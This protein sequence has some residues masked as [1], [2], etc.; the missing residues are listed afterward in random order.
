MMFEDLL[1]EKQFVIDINDKRR[2]LNDFGKSELA[3]KLEEIE[4][5]KAKLRQISTLPQKGEKG[6]K[7]MLSSNEDHTE[8]GK[9]ADIIFKKVGVSRGTYERAKFVIQYGTE[10]QKS[11]LRQN[12]TTINKEYEKIRRDRRKQQ[13][14]S[15]FGINFNSNDNSNNTENYRLIN[16]DFMEKEKQIIDN[17]IDLIL[18]DPPYGN[19]AFYIYE[20]LAWLADRV[21]KPGGSLVFYVGHLMLERVIRV[22]GDNTD[23]LKYWW[24]FCV[25]HLGNHT[26]IHAR[27]IFAEWKPMLWYVKGA[28]P[29]ESVTSNTIGDFIEST[30][31]E[32]DKALHEWEQSTTD[33]EYIIKNLTLENLT[34]LD[35]MM[36]SGTTGVS[37][38][39][40]NRKFIGFEKDLETFEIA[41]ARLNI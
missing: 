24:I 2:Q 4:S 39:N 40:L 31:P 7:S 28:G 29:N 9:T 19:E 14:L 1:E 36:G 15:K 6:F 20:S 33:A 3:Y 10:E 17:S 38:L 21:L 35:P 22:I 37:A 16:A 25:R 26:K 32:T 27:H 30:R 12:K 13:F 41:K 5:E 18:T 11:K 34:V 23:D 8:K